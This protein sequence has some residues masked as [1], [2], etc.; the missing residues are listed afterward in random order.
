MMPKA[1]N[2]VV[3]GLVGL[4]VFSSPSASQDHVVPLDESLT[5]LEWAEVSSIIAADQPELLTYLRED[6]QDFSPE[7][8]FV[9]RFDLD[10]DGTEELFVAVLHGS[11]C[12]TGGCLM[13]V[14]ERR[15]GLLAKWKNMHFHFAVWEEPSFLQANLY[16]NEDGNWIGY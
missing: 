9:G 3:S 5:I 7:I 11:N 12:G 16:K 1:M 2:I 13:Y 10:R 15:D 6:S 8:F 4:L 14:L